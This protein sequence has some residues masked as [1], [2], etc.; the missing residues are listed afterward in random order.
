MSDV[1][2]WPRVIQLAWQLFNEK[3]ELAGERCDLI[4]PEGFTVPVTDFHIKHNLTQVRCEDHGIP[5]LI[6]LQEFS[7]A[8]KE[9]KYIIAHNMDYDYPVTGAE[10][11]R[12]GAKSGSKPHK[13]CT[14]KSSTNFVGIPGK[15]GFKF[16]NLNELHNKLFQ[17]DFSG[18]HDALNDVR[19]CAKCFFE[20]IKLQIINLP[21]CQNTANE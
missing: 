11:I 13:I 7:H 12:L 17:S 14:M 6:A 16:P 8:M 5:I 20:L 18:A 2:N 9:C 21:P 1:D 15:Y 3:G 4:K 10:F 19:A